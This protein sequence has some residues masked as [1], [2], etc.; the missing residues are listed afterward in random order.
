MPKS[1]ARERRH[2]ISGFLL[3][4]RCERRG[5]EAGGDGCYE[6][7]SVYHSIT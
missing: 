4:L 2:A 1:L 5:E 7:S 6:G 3:P